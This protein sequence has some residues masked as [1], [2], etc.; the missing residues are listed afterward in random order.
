MLKCRK[1]RNVSGFFVQFFQLEFAS[2]RMW[3]VQQ[4]AQFVLWYA[5]FKSIV[6]VQ[7]K[8]RTLHPGEKAP[9]DKALN[10]WMK[11]FKETGSVSKGV[12]PGRS[13]T[14]EKNVER[15]KQSCVRSPKNFI[16]RRSLALSIARTRIQ[17]VLHKR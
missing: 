8:W 15:I 16:A 11:Q 3:T 7:R 14:L 9:D 1:C 6:V 12:S 2:R 5:E 4:K 13:S 17:N 10:R